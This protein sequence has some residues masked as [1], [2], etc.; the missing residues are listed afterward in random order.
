MLK[1]KWTDRIAYDEV[2][3]RAKEER[4]HL[5][6]KKKIDAIHGYGVKLCITSL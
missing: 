1:I 4:L 2:F 3:Q 5:K 6:I